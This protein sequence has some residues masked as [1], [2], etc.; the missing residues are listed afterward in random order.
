[1][2]DDEDY[3]FLNQWKW[4]AGITLDRNI[5]AQRTQRINGIRKQVAMHRVL[6]KVTKSESI[7]HIDR[8]GLNNQKANLRIADISQNGANSSRSKNNTSGFKGVTW[9]N[10]AK[11]WMAQ[12]EVNRHHSYLGLYDDPKEAASVYD[13]KALEAWGEFSATN[14]S[15]G[16]I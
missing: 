4:Q 11:K 15:M 6:M 1:M 14:K 10:A 16:L 8:N 5:Y 7:D 3:D 12:I 2:V 9:H 13:R